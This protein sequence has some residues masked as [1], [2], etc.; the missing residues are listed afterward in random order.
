MKPK[1]RVFSAVPFV[2]ALFF[3]LALHTDAYAVSAKSEQTSSFLSASSSSSSVEATTNTNPFGTAKFC[4]MD[5]GTVYRPDMSSQYQTTLRDN[6]ED[7]T[8]MTFMN[9]V[10]DDETGGLNWSKIDWWVDDAETLFRDD[11]HAHGIIWHRIRHWGALGTANDG[12]YDNYEQLPSNQKR[13]RDI[14]RYVKGTVTHDAR[15]NTYTLVNHPLLHPTKYGEPADYMLMGMSREEGIAQI[16]RW[17]NDADTDKTYI[18][19]EAFVLTDE[20]WRRTTPGNY[21]QLIK[22]V[23]Y[24]LGAGKKIDG[25]G[26]QGHFGCTNGEIPHP[27][28]IRDR[29]DQVYEGTGNLPMYITEMDIAFS[30]CS[31][32]QPAF[33]DPS[34]PFDDSLGNMGNSGN[35]WPTWWEYQGWAYGQLFEI[36]STHPGVVEVTM[37]DFYD[38]SHWREG[39]GL[40]YDGAYGHGD[41][42]PKPAY[43]AVKDY[44]QKEGCFGDRPI[45]ELI[46]IP[47]RIE[48]EAYVNYHD[49]DAGNNSSGT[50][51]DA[52]SIYPDDVDVAVGT[53][54][55]FAVGWILRGEWLEYEL[56]VAESNT[57]QLTARLW[58]KYVDN[59]PLFDIY[60]DGASTP[61]GSYTLTGAANARGF[62][63]FTIGDLYLDEGIHTIRVR[64]NDYR[65]N[66]DYIGLGNGSARALSTAI[67]DEPLEER[68]TG[69]SLRQLHLPLITNQ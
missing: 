18:I 37:W 62:N 26:M 49:A 66:L 1:V 53:G 17:A 27:D 8:V 11:L 24:L 69:L 25:V 54:D 29:L 52:S 59:V 20:N 23:N 42:A 15:F 6:F 57:Y 63:K 48:G 13:Q 46:Q 35:T 10:Y 22:D 44:I 2:M 55:G 3:L 38:G 47:G 7:G 28:H 21:I 58:T 16:F 50:P 41:F 34:Q 36:F 31:P 19:N 51:W 65:F 40:F 39:G 33:F 64:M 60:V 30:A 68:E 56:Y 14:R 43:H 5:M 67:H 12:W 9:N 61:Q 4:S 45:A 32:D